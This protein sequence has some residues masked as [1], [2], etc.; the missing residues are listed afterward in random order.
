MYYIMV[1]SAMLIVEVLKS[2]RCNDGERCK[3]ER[4]GH[5]C[6]GRP[7][8]C[9]LLASLPCHSRTS[10]HHHLIVYNNCCNLLI[11]TVHIY[12]H[13]DASANHISGLINKFSQVVVS[14]DLAYV[15]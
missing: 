15:M 7:V 8:T 14:T 13:T 6:G 2:N 11:I 3:P 4:A 9:L 12:A 1:K 10:V 5:V